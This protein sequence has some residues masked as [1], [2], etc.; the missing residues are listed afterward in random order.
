[1]RRRRERLA[2]VGDV[3]VAFRIINS[4]GPGEE[5]T[6][7]WGVAPAPVGWDRRGQDG[8]PAR[9]TAI[10]AGGGA[11]QSEATDRREDV[12]PCRACGGRGWKFVTARTEIAA[13]GDGP[14]TRLW[15]A[16]CGFAPRVIVVRPVDDSVSGSRSDVDGGR[17]DGAA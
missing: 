17:L 3:D 11:V 14:W 4:H 15:C 7:E 16:D 10:R 2:A 6:V 13:V 9:T 12:G 5:G 8:S 1:V